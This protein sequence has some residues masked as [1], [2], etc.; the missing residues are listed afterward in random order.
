MV[1]GSIGDSWNLISTSL[2]HN[3][4]LF[5]V[6]VHKYGEKFTSMS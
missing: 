4:I 6:A 2:V 1:S 5:G 3:N